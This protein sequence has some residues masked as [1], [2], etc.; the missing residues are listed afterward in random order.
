MSTADKQSSK[1]KILGFFIIAL[2]IET[3]CFCP[4]E[5]VT[6]RSPKTV[7]YPLGKSIIFSCTSAFFAAAIISSCVASSLPNLILSS[8][9]SENKNGSCGT[10]PI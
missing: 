4:P 8:I 2:A 3:R 6:P 5:R 1:I 9:L 10:K 7:L